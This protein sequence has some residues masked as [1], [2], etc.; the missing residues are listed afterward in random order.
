MRVN[1]HRELR[2]GDELARAGRV[3]EAVAIYARVGDH[4]VE[5][6][7]GVRA[8]ALYRQVISLV[9]DQAPEARASVEDVPR[10]LARLYRALGFD[11]DAERLERDGWR[12]AR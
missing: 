10:R 7:A 3:R 2:I 8:V 1:P 11:A 5:R 9:T 4:Y 6:G 12:A